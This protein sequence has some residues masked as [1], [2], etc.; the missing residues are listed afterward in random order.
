[1]SRGVILTLI[2]IVVLSWIIAVMV[3]RGANSRLNAWREIIKKDDRIF[4]INTMGQKTFATVL[5]VD[6]SKTNDIQLD[7]EWQGHKSTPWISS[8]LLYPAPTPTE[9]K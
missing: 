3:W 1:M 7:L 2:I 6:R 8:S 5:A 4:F 9:D